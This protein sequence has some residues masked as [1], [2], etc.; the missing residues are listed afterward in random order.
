MPKMATKPPTSC[1]ISGSFEMLWPQVF[2][3]ALVS[4]HLRP[5]VRSL[6]TILFTLPGLQ[7]ESY[8]GVYQFTIV[9]PILYYWGLSNIH[10]CRVFLSSKSYFGFWGPRPLQSW[11]LPTNPRGC[12]QKLVP[13]A[14]NGR[15]SAI[16]LKIL[17]S[18]APVYDSSVGE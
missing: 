3:W 12:G 11:Q 9:Y 16:S 5:N 18:G 4:L 17:Q 1:W 6:F 13:N 15:T 2:S 8:L 14:W 10:Y 7:K